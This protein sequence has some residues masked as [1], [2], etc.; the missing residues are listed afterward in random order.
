MHLC[1]TAR[2]W[3]TSILRP[4]SLMLLFHIFIFQLLSQPSSLRYTL[5]NNC[6]YSFVCTKAK[7]GLLDYPVVGLRDQLLVPHVLTYFYVQFLSR[8]PAH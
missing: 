3:L 2:E 8:A 6:V 5:K 1:R 7:V 4:L